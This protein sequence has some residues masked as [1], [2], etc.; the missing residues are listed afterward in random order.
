MAKR[1]QAMGQANYANGF[2]VTCHEHMLDVPL[3]RKKP[4]MYFVCSMSDLFHEDVPY[5]FIQRIFDTV[6]HTPQHTYQVLTKRPH[7]MADYATK[8][9][10]PVNVWVGTSIEDFAISTWRLP[11]LL[12]VP[13]PVRFL[14]CEPL[15]GSLQMLSLRGIDWVIAGGE[16]GP[17]ARPMDLNWAREIRDKCVGW[18]VPFLFKQIGGVNK[19]KTGR[20]LDGRTW[21]EM[22]DHYERAE[23]AATIAPSDETNVGRG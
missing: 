22:P 13:A 8:R 16:S 12:K 18:K 4:T 7:I 11:Y 9:G 17:G 19:K 23:T 21:D 14:S 10:I 15:L 2:K 5:D 6:R 1:L 20:L 3:K